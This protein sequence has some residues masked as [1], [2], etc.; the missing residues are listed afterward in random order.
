MMSFD[1]KNGLFAQKKYDFFVPQVMGILNVT[2]DSFF[3]GSR[4][5]TEYD[6][7]AR[8]DEIVS[9]GGSIIDVGGFSTRPG[10]SE[11][12]EEEEMR[13]LRF[14]LDIVRRNHKDVCLSVDTFR[15]MVA[16]MVVEEFGAD[17]INDVSEGGK[18][19]I[20]DTPLE[21]H[22]DSIPDIFRMV[23]Q[24]KVTYVLMSVQPTIEAMK[25]NFSFELAQLENLGHKDV[26]LDP[27]YGFGKSI[28]EN[29]EVLS[30]QKELMDFGLPILAG[31][32]RKRMIWQLLDSSPDKALNGTTV[33]D[34]MAMLNGASILRVHDVREAYETIKIT[35]QCLSR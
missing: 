21:G 12:C 10:A 8:A 34:T 22:N 23:A 19:G 4:K 25:E 9:E 14:A 18:T 2:P 26:I 31:M 15:P 6:I 20:V 28:E 33:V 35:E 5:Q 16:K 27:G 24:L 13:R 11:V 3:E 29:Y 30:L 1:K 7:A 17:I 32:S